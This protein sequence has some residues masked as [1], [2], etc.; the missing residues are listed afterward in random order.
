MNRAFS[1]IVFTGI[2]AFSVTSSASGDDTGSKGGEISEAG[3]EGA[4]VEDYSLHGQFTNVTQFHP[5]FRSPYRGSNSLDPGNRADETIDLTLYA[6]LR[7]WEGGEVYANPEVDQGFGLSN[8]LGVA[9]FTSGEA[10][11]VGAADPYIRLPRAFFRQTFNLGGEVEKVDPDQNQLGG[12]RQADHLIVTIGKFSV[13]DIFDT[14]S[15]AHD[16]R[17]DFLNWTII[18]AGAF[19]YAA[20]SWGYSYGAAAEWTQSWWT[21]RGGIFNLSR[22]PNDKALNRN[23]GQ[24]EFVAEGEERHTL[25]GRPGKL[26]LLAFVNYGHTARYADAVRLAA[27]TGDTPDVALVRRYQARPGFAVNFE[28]QVDD[29]LGVFARASLNDGTKEAYEFTEANRSLSIG[30]SLKGG[31]WGRPGDVIGVAGVVNDISNEARAY[32]AAGGL[33]ILIGDGQLPHYGVEGIAEAYYAL[34]VT[35]GVN[36]TVDYQYINNPGYNRDR[37]PVSVIGGRLHMEF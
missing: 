1:L 15:Y 25:F 30:A 11:K 31:D 17:T 14:N 37:G 23:F 26:K 28:Q 6:G 36:I 27:V 3:M 29:D 22:I 20:D 13:V 19:D 21:L 7:L 5:R 18:D 32:L 4:T 10:Y 9:G 33:G 12:T 8:T 34:A 35:E 2:C 16:P 24:F